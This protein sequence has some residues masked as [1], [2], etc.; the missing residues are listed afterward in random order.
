MML[1][2]DFIGCIRIM[3]LSRSRRQA[4]SN[5]D[6]ENWLLARGMC[7]LSSCPE[8]PDRKKDCHKNCKFIK[9]YKRRK[10][11]EQR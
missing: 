9:A 5:K 10:D 7:S 2:K 11:D 3:S 1:S 4:M 8:C 6:I